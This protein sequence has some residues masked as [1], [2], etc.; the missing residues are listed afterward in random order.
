MLTYTRHPDL[1]FTLFLSEG[2]TTINNWLKVV[3]RY[4][5]EGMTNRELYDLRKHTNLFSNEEIGK[6]LKLAVK[7]KPLHKPGRK[8]ALVVD[9]S[10]KFGLSRMY[11]MKSEIKGVLT[12][13][14]V[15]YNLGEAIAWLGNDVSQCVQPTGTALLKKRNIYPFSA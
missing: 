1:D 8:T 5:K 10:S 9:N 7:N 2:E 6:I 15:F 4:G 11:Q 12:R 3:Q 14:R 13:T